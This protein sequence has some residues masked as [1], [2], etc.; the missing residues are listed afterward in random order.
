MAHLV[1]V[2]LWFASFAVFPPVSARQA[3]PRPAV[4]AD[5]GEVAHALDSALARADEALA[6]G[7]PWQATRI[8]SPWLDDSSRRTSATVYLAARAARE[9]KGWSEVLQLRAGERWI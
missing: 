1:H 8:L 7:R 2:W 6:R 3:P 5:S 9:W 4:I